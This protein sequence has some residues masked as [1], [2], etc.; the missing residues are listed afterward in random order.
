MY[1]LDTL[2]CH[3][4]QALLALVLMSDNSLVNYPLAP[5]QTSVRSHV[6]SAN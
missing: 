1:L 2:S 4:C 5:L 6:Q 3:L